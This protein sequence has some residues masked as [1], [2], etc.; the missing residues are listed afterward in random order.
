[1]VFFNTG[2]KMLLIYYPAAVHVLLLLSFQSTTT[3]RVY[4]VTPDD[5]YYPNTTC[6]HC[7]N[8]Q[9]YL[10]NT[11]K[12][13]TSNT[14]LLFL[15][16]IH[17]LHTDLIIQNLHNIS[18]I[19]NNTN[20]TTPDAVIQCEYNYT[21]YVGVSIQFVKITNLTISNLV[22][23][24]CVN[25]FVLQH[26]GLE[27]AAVSIIECNTVVMYLVHIH[28]I[29]SCF[30][31]YAL[32]TVN[33][34]GQSRFSHITCYGILLYSYEASTETTEL[35]NTT[36]TYS[37]TISIDHCTV[38]I[39]D[40]CDMVSLINTYVT[41]K[42][43]G[44]MLHL[45]NM[46]IKELIS[47]SV[48]FHF[49]INSA[50]TIRITKCQFVGCSFETAVDFH[51][52]YLKSVNTAI[53]LFVKCH[54]INNKASN[55][56]LVRSNAEIKYSADQV[57]FHIYNCLF[58]YNEINNV[59]ISLATTNVKC[60]T[61]IFRNNS[62]SKLFQLHFT[63]T[64][65]I[66]LENVNFS[67]NNAN[68]KTNLIDLSNTITLIVSKLTFHENTFGIIIH[69]DASST[70][71]LHG[72]L[73]FSCNNANSIIDF[74]CNKY[75]QF[76]I[77][78]GGNLTF[79]NNHVC[80]IFRFK[81][82]AFP[83]CTFQ[84]YRY[85]TSL[86][87]QNNSYSIIF[88][89][90]HY[91][92]HCTN[93]VPLMDCHWLQDSLFADTIPIEVNNKYVKYMNSSGVYNMTQQNYYHK[94]ICLCHNANQQ[95]DCSTNELG[96]LYS[97]QTID[98]YIFIN[99]HFNK[100]KVKL[101]FEFD[102]MQSYISPCIIDDNHQ[103]L[104][105][106]GAIC[107]RVRYTVTFPTDTWCA[108]FL[109]LIG[110][111]YDD[112]NIFYI[113]QLS[114][115]PGFIK[116]N[117][118]C[119]CHPK[120][121]QL[122]VLACNINDQTILHPANSWISATPT[123]NHSYVYRISL[124][125]PFHYCLPYPSH[126][127]LSTPNDQCLFN[128]SGILCGECQQ[129]L[130]ATFVS[131][132]CQ[133]CS[134]FY[135]FHIVPIVIESIV[136]V[137]LL[138]L[139]NLTVT[140]GTI[141]AFILYVN[142]IGINSS[143]LFHKFTETLNNFDLGIFQTCFYNGMD[144]YAKMWLQLEFPFSLI[145]IATSLIITSRYSTK[146]QRLTALRA[147]PVLA[148][149]FLLSYSKILQT[150]SIVLFSYSTITELPS[151]QSTL[152]WSVDANV[153]LLGVRF[154]ILFITCLIIFLIQVPFTIIL[155]FSRPLQ[156]FH[157]INKFKPLLD[158]YQGPYKDNHYYWPGL[159]LVIGVLFLGI[160]A[161]DRDTTLAAGSIIAAAMCVI[162]GIA[163]PFKNR[164]QNCHELVLLLNLQVLHIF[165]QHNYNIT[166]ITAVIAMAAVHFTLIVVYHIITYMCGGVIR[167]KI[168]QGVNTVM[169]WINNR[170][171]VQSFQLANIP[172]VA[173]NY[174]EYREPL[175]AA[176]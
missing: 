9:H 111:S 56:V 31:L 57:W 90:N 42:S 20:G 10:L 61:C 67:Y 105:A 86:F 63:K 59:L 71:S 174:R 165:V 131:S 44:I 155:L 89:N 83:W 171:T 53:V 160:S 164:I 39:E 14:Q 112:L 139:L 109:K 45:S 122:G 138:F 88:H 135:L 154:I 134:S 100:S 55:G 120:L 34:V 114:C 7:H 24:N 142:I 158:A 2:S 16:G 103:K 92:N 140:N 176:D 130:S 46:I 145:F 80:T 108:V 33:I 66:Y 168:Q 38:Y 77:L 146:I 125:C 149:L 101:E 143:V 22:I 93:S 72:E 99:K 32:M 70:L 119:V 49:N 11:T 175:V 115:P 69:L 43:Y 60:S 126:L 128:R 118:I 35:Q 124:Q 62:N 94:T 87:K 167:K 12:Y 78:I 144:D 41:K 96:Y 98:M 64:G 159:Q 110:D 95:P 148:T 82:M 23:Q 156:R 150:V 30:P 48:V 141:N 8:L 27:G 151:E 121:V 5:H 73:H 132:Q 29:Y 51:F 6:H 3:G 129:G 136:L 137:L 54:F 113:K 81:P 117:K 37:T 65:I 166:A 169:G 116:V 170:S 173:F 58:L 172:E 97:G 52:S 104:E 79:Y 147:L 106:S 50:A 15:P 107:N 17:H 84:Y 102:T 91:N 133:H 74:S 152:V 21:T 25:Q 1:M 68:D 75:N 18:L 123:N 85:N 163:Q 76:M 127:N 153:P 19:G 157:Y 40:L 36:Y 4:T 162:T 26:G 28:K 161:L 13:F 47:R